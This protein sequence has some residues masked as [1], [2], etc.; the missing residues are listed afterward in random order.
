MT[1]DPNHIV[2]DQQLLA[3][4]ARTERELEELQRQFHDL[5][6]DVGVLIG[7]TMD[8]HSGSRLFREG[9]R[10]SSSDP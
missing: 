4:I 1:L 2:S 3:R 8:L 5:T 6:K 9:S 7:L 10:R